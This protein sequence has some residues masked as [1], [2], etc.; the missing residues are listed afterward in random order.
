MVSGS[1]SADDVSLLDN[2]LI[3]KL[4]KL[5]IFQKNDL[6]FKSIPI[7]SANCEWGQWSDWTSCKNNSSMKKDI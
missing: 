5:L 2:S 4:G 7:F 6:I 1:V 3:A